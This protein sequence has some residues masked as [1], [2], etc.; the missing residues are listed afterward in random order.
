MLKI[1]KY[2]S[3]MKSQAHYHTVLLVIK[4]APFDIGFMSS[5]LVHVELLPFPQYANEIEENSF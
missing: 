2:L 4:M 1:S 3:I 5:I